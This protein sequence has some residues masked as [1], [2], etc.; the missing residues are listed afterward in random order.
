MNK[1]YNSDELALYYKN[2]RH[3]FDEF[4]E[5]EKIMSQIMDVRAD[6]FIVL[7]VGCGCGGLGDALSK[8]Y[9]LSEYRGIDISRKNIQ[10]AIENV[11][12]NTRFSFECMDIAEDNE[13]KKFDVVAVLGVLDCNKNR[14]RIVQSCWTKV[15][16]GI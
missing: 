2:N 9:N 13:Q 11:R 16:G 8:K 6:P 5:S 7:D 4:Y 1:I 15:C 10:C 3:N 14:N 12:L